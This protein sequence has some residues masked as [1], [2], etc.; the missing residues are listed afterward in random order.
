MVPLEVHGDLLGAEV[1]V[2]P[3]IGEV[4]DHL[5]MGRVERGLGRLGPGTQALDA[6]GLVAALR[7]VVRLPAD[8]EVPAGHRDVPGDLFDVAYD[9]QAPLGLTVKAAG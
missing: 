7:G 6:V 1:V 2:L 8:P 9:G 4:P 3:K 5:E